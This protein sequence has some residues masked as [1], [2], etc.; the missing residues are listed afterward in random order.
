MFEGSRGRRGFTVNQ[1]SRKCPKNMEKTTYL[2]NGDS[3]NI[4]LLLK[5]KLNIT[6]FVVPTLEI[7]L[8]HRN[9]FFT[10]HCQPQI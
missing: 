5:Q 3:L 2:W 10:D 4:A 1:K 8:S 6:W 9:F 7:D